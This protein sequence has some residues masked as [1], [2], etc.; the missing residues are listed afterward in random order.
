MK[1]L[2]CTIT[3]FLLTSGAAYS[4]EKELRFS[5]WGGDARHRPTLEVARLF[6]AANPGVKIKCEYMGFSGYL[7]RLTT[8]MSGGIE[9]DIMQINW[10]WI[11]TMLSKDGSGFFNLYDAKKEMN[12]GEWGDSLRTGVWKGRLNAV[13][14][15]FTARTF[16]WQKTTLDKAGV[17]VPRTWDDFLAMGG[18]FERKLGQN[19]YPMD[20]QWYVAFHLVHAY[21]L[22]K[23]GKHWIDPSSSQ[24]A[25]SA[26][27]AAEF[28]GF[29]R[30]LCESRA[31]VPLGLRLSIGGQDTPPEQIQ[32]WVSGEWAG[33][34][35]WDSD[36]KTRLSS[37]PKTADVV[38][39]SF[40][41][42]KKTK[43]SG[44]YGRPSMMLAVS[45]RSRYP[46]VAARFIN[47]MLTDSRAVRILK[48]TRGIPIAK[49]ARGILEKE[50]ML[51]ALDKEALRETKRVK[52]DVPSAYVEHAKIL[53]L[54]RSTLEE[55]SLGK[56]SDSQAAERLT[57]GTDRVLDSI[58]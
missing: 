20:G 28:A 27:D 34:N 56:I 15:S 44:F 46:L 3:I 45:K 5:W 24:V 17:S 9:S 19:Y 36:F 39:G 8:Q 43:N 41:T 37:L 12:F 26:S 51:S 55:I 38:H 25:Y 54:M 22:Q 58:R 35:T 18:V 13:P 21:M 49:S 53:E 32:A 33:S 10:A 16:L 48:D 2:I 23:T 31:I 29:Y 40:L 57:S 4:E 14:I 7:E 50:N 52:I 47:F 42:M 1:N 11:S 6:E 30:K